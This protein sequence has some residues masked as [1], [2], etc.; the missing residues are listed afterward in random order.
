MI[1]QTLLNCSLVLHSL[2]INNARY[3]HDRVLVNMEPEYTGD[4]QDYPMG[5]DAD[6]REGGGDFVITRVK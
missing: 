4:N 5:D 2:S 1:S 3:F 6:N